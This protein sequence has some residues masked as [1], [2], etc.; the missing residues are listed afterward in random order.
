MVLLSEVMWLQNYRI[1]SVMEV[2]TGEEMDTVSLDVYLALAYL[3][4]S[5]N[6]YLQS[7]FC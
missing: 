1:I 3:S 5:V 6:M 4:G 7:E 2:F